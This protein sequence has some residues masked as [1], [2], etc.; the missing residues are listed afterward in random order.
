MIGLINEFGRLLDAR[1]KL[2]IEALNGIS[3][4]IK[5]ED[6]EAGVNVR[7][8]VLGTRVEEPSEGQGTQPTVS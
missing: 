5:P 8:Q 4:A 7:P 1:S 3:D 2:M 6:N